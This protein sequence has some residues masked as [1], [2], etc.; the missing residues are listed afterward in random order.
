MAELKA[1]KFDLLS[2]ADIET[3]SSANIIE[4]SD[5][6]SAKLG[7]PNA[8]PQCVTC[9]SQNVRDCDGHSGVIKLPA[10]VYSPY[11]LEQL[12]QFLNQICPG[13]W[14]P[15]QNRDT[16]RSDAATIQ[17][18]CKY[19]SKDGLYPSVIFKV[20]TSPRIT[21][22][23]SKLQ[24]NTS[25]M[26]KVSVTA[27]VINM[28]KNKSS[29]EVLPHDYWNFVP[30]NQPPQPN[31]TKILLSPYQVFHIL[32][33]VDLELI[34][35]FAPRREL[36]FLSCLPV[37]PN[38]HR[39]AEMPY[40]FSDG[41]SLAY[42]DRTKA[43]KRTVD[44]SKKID[45]YRQH[46]QFSVLASS[47]VT[48]RV[49]ECLQSSKLYSK[50]TDKESSTDSYGTS[51]KKNDS[52]G[53]KWLKDAILSK[54]SD[55]AF[56][57]IMVGDPKIR[58]HEIGIPMD[59]ADL[60]VPEHVSI[61]NFKSI[62]LKCNLH[63][64]AKEL[65]IA[66]RNGKLIYVRK[67]NQLEIGDIVYRPLQDGDL[68]LVNRPPS[69]HQHS[70]IALSAKLLPV[71]SVVAINPLNCAPLSGDFDGDCLHGYVPQSIGS[72]VE[73]GELVSLSHQLLNMQ[74]GRSLVSLTHDSL[75]AAHL[76]TS[77]GVL[78]NKTEFQQL[79]MLC[80]S[81]SP[82]P[83]PSVIK[84]INPQGPLWT[85][86][87]LFGMLLP[88]G[89]N[90]SPDP[91]LHIKDSEVLACSGGSFWLQNNTS[92]L[93][94]VL[95]KQYGGEALEFLSSAQDMLCE[96]LTMRGLSVSLSDIY[97]FSDH[98]SRRKFAE[99]VNLALDEAEEAFRVTQILLSPNFIPHLKCYDDCDDLSD[100]YEQSDFVQSNLPIIKSS[101]MAFKSVFSDLL[102]MV[103]QH[104]PKDNSMMAMINAGS[105]G[106]MLKFVQQ[107][108]C[109]GL[110]LPAG[111]FPFRIP[112]ELTCASW[113]RH[114]SLDCDISEGARKRLGGQNSHA[115]IRNSFIEGLN[116]LECL[117]HSI[118]GRANFFSENADVPGTLTK[119]LM[120]HLRDIYVAYDGTVRSS[121]GQQIVQFTYDTAEDI[122]TDCGQEGEFGAPVGSWAACSISEA[123]YGALDHP[124]NVIEDS[125][126]MNLQEVLKC[127]KGTNSLDHFGL[128]FLSKN[129]KKYRYG[130][131]YAS[132]YVQNYLEPMDFS[133]L[134]NTVMI[135]Y[136]GGGVQKTKGSPWITHFHI[137]KE[138][139]KR[140]RLG[141]RL[142]VEDLTEH[143]N[144][145]R[146][147][148]NNVI[149]KVY[150]SKCKCSDDDDCINNQTCCITVVAQDE[151]NSTS[152]SQLDDLKKRAIPVLLATPV[153]GFLEF[154]DVEIQCQR[155]NELVVKVNMSKHCKSGIFWT[156]LKKACIGI[157]G[158]IDWERSRP[159]SVYDIFC[160]CGIDSAWKYFV[161]SL[162][163]KTD[164]IGR[165]IHREHLLVVADTLSVS[166]QFHGLSSQGLKQQ[167]TQLSTSSP[168]SEACFSRPADTFI[169]AAKQCSVDNL[170]GNIDALAWGKEPPAG[171]SGPFKIMYAGKPHEPVQN[172]NIYGFLH[173]P[174]VWGP[175]KNHMETDSTRTKNASERWSSGNATFNGGTIS[176]EQNYLG[177]KVGVW[178]SIIDMRTC[179]QNMLREYQLDEYV[180]ELDKSR[181]IE[182]LRF[183]PRGREKIG[184]GIRDIKIGQHPSHPGTRCFILV[185]NDD[186]T[187]DVSYKK[188]VQG[189]ADSISPQ[190][191]SHMEKI[192]QTRS[193]CRD[194]W[195]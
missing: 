42:D 31:T 123:A 97:L 30:H 111:K 138:M 106:S 175:E 20:L 5:V 160:P 21:L 72:R 98:Y 121:Y 112:S 73:L 57:S 135:Q 25:V 136:D 182:A 12:V 145:K 187:E 165:N 50:K 156:T 86:K 104:T 116:P 38:R 144:A 28:S 126:L 16:K 158:L 69:V 131:E 181:V 183:H 166:G 46:P 4:A 177:A 174:E 29:L 1:L 9:G 27:E 178:D 191:G 103:Q 6:T 79:Q 7:L 133:E 129:L 43:Y 154:K 74:D 185:R 173:N 114:K 66:R 34:T 147:Q 119:N 134:V 99:E 55:Y 64:L 193:F 77:S 17:E 164:D 186:T 108:A 82:T 195:R 59:L 110:Q 33:Q 53:T 93:F 90:F 24:R 15:K 170:C 161:E 36:L 188:C 62:N 75:A 26:D 157:M 168:F 40:R 153:K 127:Q 39:V 189:A 107:A 2:S 45:D 180:V 176:V 192:L 102:K 184:V 155:D 125:P 179:L 47:F 100:S 101:I 11:F 35:K 81:L 124:V 18:P 87:Q 52:Y 109:V 128:L 140:K 142:L 117:L 151:S 56:R 89:M 149:P 76:L 137:S 132:L 118:S 96:F 71:Q 120:Y 190:L 146:D 48:S 94:S 143:Y 68:I 22:S 85:G 78:L 152:T 67:E 141:L 130:F 139:M 60:F 115:V 8:A 37:T 162:R 150:I 113:N 169:K 95:F 41:P 83:V 54:R 44:A 88:S 19:C 194:S 32:K 14:T 91:K 171:T 23:K 80:V 92:G 84:S 65:L 63:L 3:L 167:R 51:V 105:K 122:Y 10:T 13:C 58:L 49:M 148:L 159:G 70:L 163:S 61:Y 172:E